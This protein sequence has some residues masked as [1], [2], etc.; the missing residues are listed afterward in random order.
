MNQREGF[1]D[2]A[3]GGFEFTKKMIE[4]NLV[5]VEAGKYETIHQSAGWYSIARNG[6]T[7][8][9]TARIRGNGIQEYSWRM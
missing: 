2:A 6:N 5:Q 9:T 1:L 4:H 3:S 7:I 8:K